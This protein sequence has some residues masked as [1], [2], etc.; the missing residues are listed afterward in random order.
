MNSATLHWRLTH[1]YDWDMALSNSV[2]C[3]IGDLLYLSVL[4]GTLVNT[5]GFCLLLVFILFSAAGWNH[6]QNFGCFELLTANLE[7]IFES[8]FVGL[9]IPATLSVFSNPEY[10]SPKIILKPTLATLSISCFSCCVSMQNQAGAPSQRTDRTCFCN[11]SISWLLL[12]P[13]AFSRRISQ[14]RLKAFLTTLQS[15]KCLCS[16][17]I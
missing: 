7:V 11:A 13:R 2:R 9:D 1:I 16:H 8:C 6:L 15:F 10:A 12:A 4:H 17:E 5:W 14:R 3:G